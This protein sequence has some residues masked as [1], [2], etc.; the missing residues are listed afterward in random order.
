MSLSMEL[1]ELQAR[2]GSRTID[3]YKDLTAAVTYLLY[4]SIP[5]RIECDGRTWTLTIDPPHRRP[6]PPEVV[7][8]YKWARR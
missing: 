6:P 7:S 8:R 4:Y 5:Y 1:E 2:G 3:K